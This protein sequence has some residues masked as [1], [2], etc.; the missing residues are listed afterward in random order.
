MYKIKQNTRITLSNFVKNLRANDKRWYIVTE[1]QSQNQW[2]ASQIPGELHISALT[3][4]NI[5]SNANRAQTSLWQKASSSFRH[6][7]TSQERVRKVT[8][9]VQKINTRIFLGYHNI[10]ER[11]IIIL[12]FFKKFY[13]LRKVQKYLTNNYPRYNLSVSVVTVM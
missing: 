6:Y 13:L 8:I 1:R 12:I 10:N 3:A 11:I 2:R 7:F 4:R 5:R 9:F